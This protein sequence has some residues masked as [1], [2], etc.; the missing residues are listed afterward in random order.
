MIRCLI[1]GQFWIDTEDYTYE[2]LF[3]YSFE[4][5]PKDKLKLEAL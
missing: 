2:V 5:M 1:F 3:N 4:I